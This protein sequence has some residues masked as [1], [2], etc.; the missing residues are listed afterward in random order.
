MVL[1]NAPVRLLESNVMYVRPERLPMEMFSGPAMLLELSVS[2]TTMLL[3][4]VMPVKAQAVGWTHLSE[5]GLFQELYIA[6]RAVR[7][8]EGDPDTAMS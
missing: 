1:G 2:E 7:S 3:V 6:R 4:H 5:V 8:V